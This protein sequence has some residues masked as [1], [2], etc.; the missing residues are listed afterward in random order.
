M[1][2]SEIGFTQLTHLRLL[3][4]GLEPG[5]NLYTSHLSESFN[6]RRSPVKFNGRKSSLDVGLSVS[7]TAYTGGWC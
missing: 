4:G 2:K 5:L 1:Y 6:L 7:S 3:L